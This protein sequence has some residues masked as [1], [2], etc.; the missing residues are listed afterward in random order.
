M[1]FSFLISLSCAPKSNQDKTEKTVG[2]LN[3]NEAINEVYYEPQI[4]LKSTIAKKELNHTLIAFAQ[5]GKPTRLVVPY[6][7]NTEN[8]SSVKVFRP[9]FTAVG[10]KNDEIKIPVF[11]VPMLG[12]SGGHN[13]TEATMGMGYDIKEAIAKQN[14]DETISII[15]QVPA[16]CKSVELQFEAL[17]E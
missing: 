14:N 8:Y 2:F 7:Y 5:N 3:D 15:F 13:P 9:A 1:I 16:A 6:Y 4:L 12:L 17:F 10:C 11:G